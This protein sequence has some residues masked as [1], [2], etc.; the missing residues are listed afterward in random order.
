MISSVSKTVVVIA[1]PTA[2][3]KTE[4]CVQ[5][6]KRLNTVVVSA[7][8]RQL[9]RELTIGTAKPSAA[10]LDNVPH[11]F[12]DSHSVAAPI[13][14]GQYE[15]EALALFDELFEIHDTI[16]LTGGTGLY[17]NAVLKGLDDMP[18]GNTLLRSQLQQQ[19]EAE[20]ITPLQARLLQLDPAYAALADLNNTQRV[21]RALEVCLTT[22][23]PY[24]WFRRRVAIDRPFNTKLFALQRPREELYSRINQ[25]IDAMLA[26]GL[27]DEVRGLQP[28]RHTPALQTVGYKEVFPYLDGDYD[29]DTMVDLLKRNSRRYAKRQL[30]W[31]RHQN[32]FDWFNP[33]DW[34]AI[35][36][37]IKT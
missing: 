3:G 32:Q 5:L 22:G 6:A 30:T 31:F 19:F 28:Y 23:K 13:S 2:V 7:D 24:S 25:R 29:Y 34:E 21:M 18:E 36:A 14:A 4:L 8:S 37:A 17:I 16:I 15:R 35:L 1:G 12:I 20:G 26:N 27:V 33:Q 10:E 9:Y 11:Y